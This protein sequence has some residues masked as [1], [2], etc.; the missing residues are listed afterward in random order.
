M[1]AIDLALWDLAG[2]AAGLPVS[3]LLGGRRIDSVPV[4]ASEVIPAAPEQVRTMAEQAV[5]AGYRA[6]SSVGAR[7]GRSS[8]AT[9]P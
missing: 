9:S 4:Y 6:S 8:R 1:S 2:K 7:S 3:E 5:A